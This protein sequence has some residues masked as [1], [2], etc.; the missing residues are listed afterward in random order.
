MIIR[1]YVQLLL[2]NVENKQTVFYNIKEITSNGA[3]FYADGSCDF[4]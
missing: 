1:D 2:K 3:W 4:N